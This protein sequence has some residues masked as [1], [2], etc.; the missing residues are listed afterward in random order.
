M[1]THMCK[2]FGLILM[3]GSIHQSFILYTYTVRCIH[4]WYAVILHWFGFFHPFPSRTIA[5]WSSLVTCVCVETDLSPPIRVSILKCCTHRAI[6]KTDYSYW[7]LILAGMLTTVDWFGM[8]RAVLTSF[9]SWLSRCV[10]KQLSQIRIWTKQFHHICHCSTYNEYC[11][12]LLVLL[13][14]DAV[15]DLLVCQHGKVGAHYNYINMYSGYAH[16]HG[17]AWTH[18]CMHTPMHTWMCVHT[19]TRPAQWVTLHNI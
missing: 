15:V 7:W 10:R 19:C 14:S 2:G 13:S 6:S 4:A 18:S 1:V 9:S 3:F 16:F 11:P 12:S 5:Y 17:H 8:Q